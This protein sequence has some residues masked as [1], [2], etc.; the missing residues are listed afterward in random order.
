[1]PTNSIRNFSLSDDKV[2]MHANVIL[3]SFQ[4]HQSHFN[5]FSEALFPVSYDATF[6]SIIDT[7]SAQLSDRFV[8]KEQVQESAEVASAVD[9]ALLSLKELHYFASRIFPKE[10]GVLKRFNL[11][12]LSTKSRSV[13]NFIGYISDVA[14]VVNSFSEE[15]IV[16]GYEEDKIAAFHQM[17]ANVTLQRREQKEIK[18]K[19]TELTRERIEKMNNLWDR[20]VDLQKASEI[21][22]TNNPDKAKLFHLP[23]KERI[24]DTK[25]DSITA[26]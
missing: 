18:L 3:V 19:R 25:S 20:L 16:G 7:A 2:I 5:H 26:E 14:S 17:V 23:Q 24:R 12:A 10:E 8:I 6:K 21:I 1:M 9:S 13:D 15:L 11:N 4:E 22:F